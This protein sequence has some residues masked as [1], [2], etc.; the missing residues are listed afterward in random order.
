MS[1]P[2]KAK[3]WQYNVNQAFNTSATPLTD[4]RALLRGIKNT[5]IGFASNP[6]QVRGSSNAVSA[7]LL[8]VGAAG[9]GTDYWA[10][11]GDLVWANAGVAHSWIV[12]RQTQ[13]ASNFEILI[14]CEGASGAGLIITVY[15]SYSAGF[16]GGSTTA[17]P[18]ATDE[19]AV[20]S[21]TDFGGI[22]A[23][24]NV[25]L[26]VMM[27]S[28][29]QCTRMFIYAS[30]VPIG[31]AFFEKPQNP[32]TGWS[33]PSF[34]AWKGSNTTSLAS[35]A[36]VTNFYAAASFNG[37]GASNMT[38]FGTMESYNSLNLAANI[39]QT[40]DLSSTYQ[41]YPVGLAS[42]TAAN[43]GRHGNAFDLWWA[44]TALGEGDAAPNDGT[45]QFIVVGQFWMP[46]DGSIPLTS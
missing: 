18:T 45:R 25:K 29:G 20:I 2:S 24:L 8:A 38:M 37:R 46:W 33:N 43:K 22:N 11:N 4:N 12:L 14:S 31:I 34:A 1:L 6:W 19:A 16:T 42:T 23:A 15:V 17:R 39:D 41:M 7:A 27:S 26:H 21:G 5:L 35:Q 13:I 44:N 36:T 3:T 10:A 32:V 9:P 40:N 30:G 28:D